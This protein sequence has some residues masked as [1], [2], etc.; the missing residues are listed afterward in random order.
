MNA[1]LISICIPAYKRTVELKRLFNSIVIQTFKDF[2]IVI[3]DDSPEESVAILCNE[4]R[5]KLPIAYYKNKIRLGSPANFNQSIAKAT[6]EWIKMMNDDD[7]FAT[8][9]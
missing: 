4:Y 9:S 1:P 6:G 3:T 2:E 5:S 7:W 8:P